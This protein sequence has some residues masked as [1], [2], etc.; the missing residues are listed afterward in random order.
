MAAGCGSCRARIPKEKELKAARYPRSNR[1]AS[2]FISSIR[3][4]SSIGCS[5]QYSP[6]RSTSV[7]S[8]VCFP[9]FWHVHT[10]V[11]DGDIYREH[12]KGF[13]FSQSGS[14]CGH[15]RGSS[16]RSVSSSLSRRSLSQAFISSL[17]ITLS[18][19]A[20]AMAAIT[21]PMYSI[22]NCIFVL[23]LSHTHLWRKGRNSNPQSFPALRFSRP[24]HS[25]DLPSRRNSGQAA[26]RYLTSSARVSCRQP[27]AHQAR[28]RQHCLK[29]TTFIRTRCGPR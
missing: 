2:S 13:P 1:R 10:D 24:P 4:R 3:S 5:A 22:K 19:I 17:T 14:T 15:L 7:L 6:T 11:P 8:Y 9:Q 21:Q 28:P 20:P 26:G 23:F 25:T 29:L 12:T 27:A 18:T 16:S